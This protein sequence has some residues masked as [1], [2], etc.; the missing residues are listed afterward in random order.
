[1]NAK[2]DKTEMPMKSNKFKTGRYQRK[3]NIIKKNRIFGNF[4][5]QF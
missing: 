4:I 2:L 5:Y 3:Q 1:M